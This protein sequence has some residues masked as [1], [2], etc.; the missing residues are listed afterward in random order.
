M[1]IDYRIV[2]NYFRGVIITNTSAIASQ[3]AFEGRAF[4][5]G[6][7]TVYIEEVAGV[8]D[9]DR[10]VS[11]KCAMR[12]TFTYKIYAKLGVDTNIVETVEGLRDEIAEEFLDMNPL[13]LDSG[14]L[15]VHIERVRR[16][17]ATNNEGWRLS[18]IDVTV[19]I[20]EV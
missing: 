5:S 2:R 20:N 15:E 1:S 18:P 17:P 10:F 3:M 11:G 16:R 13:L 4:D 6:T 9:E 12:I 19:K 8:D 14:K 7:Q